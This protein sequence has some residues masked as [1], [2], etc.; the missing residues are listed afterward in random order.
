MSICWKAHGLLPKSRE[1]KLG[2]SYSTRP[3]SSLPTPAI[4]VAGHP[5]FHCKNVIGTEMTAIRALLVRVDRVPLGSHLPQ[6]AV[7]PL[8]WLSV[9]AQLRR[10]CTRDWWKRRR[11]G[12]FATW[13][14]VVLKV[15]VDAVGE[16]R[17]ILDRPTS[18][19]RVVKGIESAWI[20]EVGRSVC[21]EYEH[22]E[23]SAQPDRILRHESAQRR[24]YHR[25]RM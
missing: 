6:A 23:S 13:I 11:P 3:W 4:A 19:S 22:V 1:G 18:I 21:C 14:G 7:E 25:A 16:C 10:G 5:E 2:M 8:G 24:M 20:T 12:A 17:N 9:R 15:V